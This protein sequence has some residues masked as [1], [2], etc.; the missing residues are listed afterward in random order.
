MP[1]TFFSHQAPVLPLK[2]W[3]PRWFCG[4]A[5]VIGSMAP[6]FESFVTG[7]HSREFGHT[8]LAQ[9]WFCLPLTLALVWLVTRIVARP[10]AAALPEAGD[11]HLRDYRALAERRQDFRYWLLAVLSALVASFSH[12]FIDAFTHRTGWMVQHS[13]AL[14]GPLLQVHGH[15][16][17]V[18]KALQHGGS[19]VGAV[20]TL[21]MLRYIGRRRLLLRWAGLPV[22]RLKLPAPRGA[23]Q[24]LLW[25][26]VAAAVAGAVVPWALGWQSGE[27]LFDIAAEASFRSISW[28]FVGL[29]AACFWK[30]NA[31]TD[32]SP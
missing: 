19:I 2:L 27:R 14:Q 20:L 8:L 13:V 23:L 25:P 3:R 10:L 16:L 11:F 24:A 22:P 5:L 32:G 1:F 4:T 21:L 15:T 29:S 7:T 30:R 26:A 31:S 6:D 12:L 18:Y 28:G 17:Q 9:L